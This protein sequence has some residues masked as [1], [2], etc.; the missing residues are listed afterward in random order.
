[1]RASERET[2]VKS[3]IRTARVR[4]SSVGDGAK[5]ISDVDELVRCLMSVRN[6]ANQLRKLP[7][8][9]WEEDGMDVEGSTTVRK[10]DTHVGCMT[11]C[12]RLATPGPQYA[13]TAKHTAN[14]GQFKSTLY[15]NPT[16]AALELWES[17]GAMSGRRD[18]RRSEMRFTV[19]TLRTRVRSSG[20]LC[21]LALYPLYPRW[22]MS[23]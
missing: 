18:N 11:A 7:E 22:V 3:P 5:G 16:L 6:C 8:Y 4:V 9:R 23:K 19:V 13:L 21:V 1:M 14:M 2:S 15:Q 20:S 17:T 12:A 10:E